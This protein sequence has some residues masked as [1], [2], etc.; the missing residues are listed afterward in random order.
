MRA[1]S[2]L[3]VVEVRHG[4]GAYVSALDASHLLGPLNFFLTLS[5]V[6]VEKLY[7]ARRLIEGE[8]CALA[9]KRVTKAD[10][11]HLEAL[12]AQQEELT[13]YAEEY[14]K[15]DSQFHERLGEISDNPFLARAQQS[16]NILGIEF[17]LQ[18]ARTKDTPRRS[19]ADHRSILSALKDRD[20]EKA[21]SAMIAHMNRVYSST[22]TSAD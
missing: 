22:I 17:R 10:L 2:A 11:E 1:L 8:I 12:T 21:R 4:G 18:V 6:S 9:A 5:E 13:V 14:L 16:L 20:P 19:I 3:G 7:D 15:L